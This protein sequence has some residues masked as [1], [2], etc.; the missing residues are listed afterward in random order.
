LRGALYFLSAVQ[1]FSIL[2]CVNDARIVREGEQMEEQ[3]T[4]RPADKS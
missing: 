3:L 4:F 2:L 1:S